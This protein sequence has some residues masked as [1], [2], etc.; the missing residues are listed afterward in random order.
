MDKTYKYTVCTRCFTYN[1]AQYIIDAL[2]GF[3]IQQTSF[4]F[5]CTI[6]DDASTDGEQE[7]IGKYLLEH[8]D[9]QDT[10]TAYEVDKEYGHVTFARHKTNQNCFF[11]VLYLTENHYSQRKSKFPYLVEWIDNCKYLALCEGDDY[12][13]DSLKL[14]KQVMFL[15]EHEDYSMCSCTA[16]WLTEKGLMAWGCRMRKE[17][18]VT[19]DQLITWGG[20]SLATASIV[21]RKEL[22]DVWPEWRITAV[23]AGV[24]D[25]PLKILGS[26]GKG[27][28]FFP[29]VMCVYRFG[30]PGS[31]TKSHNKL[32]FLKNKIEWMTL[33]DK[34]TNHK[35]QKA[36]YDQLFR[37]YSSLYNL[38]EISFWNYA[39]AVQRSGGKRY[40]RLFN[41]FVRIKL[42]PVY[43]FLS[44]FYK[45]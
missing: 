45:K 42:S 27:I 26:F 39:L 44:H 9:L 32:T 31:W 25:F 11:A 37:H 21:Y 40:R 20:Y 4:P 28:H 8:F 2:N 30:H 5:V 33:L 41:D 19:T 7:I 3:V 34:D 14:Q 6:V 36:I 13:T 23:R 18:D 17:G 43:R 15:D 35:F 29:Q 10:S 22:S 12:W 24:G 16:D 38:R 1:Q